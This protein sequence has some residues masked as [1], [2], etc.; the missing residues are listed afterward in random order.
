ME[1]T[2]T[3]DDEPYAVYEE[4]PGV[5]EWLFVDGQYIFNQG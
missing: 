2:Q 1:Q 4:L 3:D 5:V